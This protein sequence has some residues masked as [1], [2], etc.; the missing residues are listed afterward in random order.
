M[1]QLQQIEANEKRLWKSAVTLR[2]NP[3]VGSNE[4]F[5]PAMELIFLRHAYSSGR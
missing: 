2:S 1:Q 3:E 5:M 4:S